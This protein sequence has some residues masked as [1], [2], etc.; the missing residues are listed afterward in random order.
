MD[1][2]MPLFSVH[3]QAPALETQA[4]E[5]AR[6]MQF[7]TASREVE[8]RHKRCASAWETHLHRTREV[9]LAAADRAAGQRKALVLGAGLLHD[10]PLPELAARFDQVL[11][12]DAFHSR[13]CKIRAS[14]FPNVIC[15]AA[16]VTGTSTHLLQV[17]RSGGALLRIEA[18]LL[19][20]DPDIDFTVSVNMLSQLGCA[21]AQLLRASH[22]EAEIQAFQR[23]LIESHL[24]Y[25]RRRGG[26]TALVT[27][28][29]WSRRP[30]GSTCAETLARWDVLHQTPLPETDHTWEWRIAPAPESD[31]HLDVIAHV[32]AFPD[33]KQATRMVLR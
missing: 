11:L 9:I 20:D 6:E 7:D 30:V 1:R 31:P 10:I 24:A 33:W 16:D 13:A 2:L 14:I 27:D 26:H 15:L 23:H 29:A 12:V 22:S 18:A 8:A 3:P 17:R 4:A 28:Y 21:P 32:A 19:E 25:L 5:F